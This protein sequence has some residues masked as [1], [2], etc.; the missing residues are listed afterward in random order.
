MFSEKFSPRFSDTDALGHINNTLV[1]I[2]FEGARKPVFELFVPDLDPNK[3][4]LILANIEVAFKAQMYFGFDMEVKTFISHIG[5][6][7][8]KVY[9]ELWQQE[10]CCAT[11]TA[12]MVHFDYQAQKPTVIP[13]QIKQMLTAHIR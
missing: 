3:W 9:Q 7:S 12:T 6:S 1:P 5:N 4:N 13:E 2:W 11:G 10:K 8:F